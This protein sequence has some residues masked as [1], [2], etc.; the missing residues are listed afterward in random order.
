[1]YLSYKVTFHLVN[2][3]HR[4]TLVLVLFLTIDILEGVKLTQTTKSFTHS[5]AFVFFRP[6]TDIQR[7]FRQMLSQVHARV[8]NFFPATYLFFVMQQK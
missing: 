3:T 6:N 2:G 4:K 5:C 7:I 8:L 1:M